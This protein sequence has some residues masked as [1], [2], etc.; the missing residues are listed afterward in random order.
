[1]EGVIH[2]GLSFIFIQSGHLVVLY[3]KELPHVARKG[4]IG[5]Q[6][7]QAYKIMHQPGLGE[8]LYSHPNQKEAATTYWPCQRSSMSFLNSLMS[9]GRITFPAHRYFQSSETLE[10]GTPML[11]SGHMQPPS[12]TAGRAQAPWS[13]TSLSAA[14]QL[15][16]NKSDTW[17]THRTRAW[18]T[19]AHPSIMNLCLS[20]ACPPRL[21]RLRR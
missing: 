4:A 19:Y 20:R 14:T 12:C 10:E 15:K 16:K 1:V 5:A 18:E 17:A 3:L 13:A 7:C 8:S 21:S 2:Q 6:L 9:R 11:W